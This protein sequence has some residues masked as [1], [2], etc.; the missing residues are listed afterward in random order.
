MRSKRFLYNNISSVLG[1]IITIICGMI[2]PKIMMAS[3]GSELYGATTS[4]TDFLGYIALIEG[5]IGGVARAAL[6]KPLAEQD[7]HEV[8]KI[9]S[10]IQQ[11]FRKIATVF[12]G[13]SLVLACSYSFIAKDYTYDWGFTFCLVLI[14]SLSSLTEYYFGITYSVL[15]QADQRRYIT[16]NLQSITLILNTVLTCILIYFNYNILVVKL[17]YC[18]LHIIR[19][20]ILNIY[21][22]KNYTLKKMSPQKEYLSQKWDGMGQ[23]IAYFLHSKTDIAVLTLF[24]N[25]KEVAVYSIYNYIV[26]SL[27]TLSTSFVS[28]MEAVFGNMLVK[29]ETENLNRF[30]NLAEFMIH[31]IIIILFSTAAIM[32]MPFIKLYTTN[33]SDADYYRPEI[34]FLMLLAEALFCFRQPYSQLAIAAGEFKGTKN[35][36]F[37][38]AGINIILS[39]TLVFFYG[40]TGV[41]MA[42]VVAM[43]YRTIFYV[44]YMSKHIIERKTLLFIKRLV[45]T[46]INTTV[47]YIVFKLLPFRF[48][49][50]KNYFEWALY[51]VITVCI[52]SAITAIFSFIF[53]QQEWKQSVNKVIQIFQ[54]WNKQNDKR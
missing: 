34:A 50:I 9:S 13:Y 49:S 52:S 54:K 48:E 51:A 38:E 46:F 47:I 14:I 7:F 35:A 17:L 31:T 32:I 29:K 2:L 28:G 15:L 23:H 53:Y 12:I 22:R 5:G 26:T 33:I 39:C 4:I 42:T 20:A 43:A 21:I 3:F 41:V 27:A 18:I 10:S 11:F 30:F 24:V 8:S 25:L 40:M 45:L 44:Y 37:I 16:Q 6:Y 19:I 1:Q 36:A